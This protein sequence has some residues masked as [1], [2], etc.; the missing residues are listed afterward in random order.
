MRR[1]LH[2]R[3]QISPTPEATHRGGWSL[4]LYGALMSEPLNPFV[5]DVVALLDADLREQ[6]EE[7]AAI[8]E[9]DGGLP[10][11]RAEFLAL[12]VVLRGRSSALASAVAIEIEI[13]GHRRWILA[14]NMWSTQESVFIRAASVLDVLLEI[15]DS[16]ERAA[17][18]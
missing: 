12:I 17:G 16:L 13:D 3:N 11:S 9:F 5:A 6:F 8:M 7:R 14:N 1:A 2:R 18:K 4:Y 10:R 15:R